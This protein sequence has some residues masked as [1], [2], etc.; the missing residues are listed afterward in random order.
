MRVMIRNEEK[1]G[2][3]EGRKYGRRRNK[4][5]SEDKTGERTDLK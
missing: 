2:K 3:T 1:V 4:L 5:G